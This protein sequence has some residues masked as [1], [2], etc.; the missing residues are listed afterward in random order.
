MV[1]IQ[2]Y[3]R[4]TSPMSET[5]P[6]QNVSLKFTWMYKVNRTSTFEGEED[7]TEIDYRL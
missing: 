7:V 6:D 1:A 5:A 4:G 3:C 2:R